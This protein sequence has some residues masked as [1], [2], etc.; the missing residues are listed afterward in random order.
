MS[1]DSGSVATADAT[2]V[3]TADA[4][5]V[6]TAGTVS[7][8]DYAS[9]VSITVDAKQLSAIVTDIVS[10]IIA[11]AVTDIRKGQAP[12]LDRI[13]ALSNTV[14][15]MKNSLITTNQ[16]IAELKQTGGKRAAVVYVG[17][18]EPPADLFGNTAN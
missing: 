3:A 5:A 11:E 14:M 7:E 16:S 12:I 9:N 13:D 10:K 8:H 17:K 6:A 4:T 18:T 15:T 1:N 2:A